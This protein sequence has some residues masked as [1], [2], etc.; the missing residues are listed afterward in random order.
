MSFGP[1][2][3]T[4]LSKDVPHTPRSQRQSAGLTRGASVLPCPRRCPLGGHAQPWPGGRAGLRGP[5]QLA[6]GEQT[7]ESRP[8]PQASPTSPAG[9]G[10]RHCRPTAAHRRRGTR[11]LRAPPSPPLAG[12]PTRSRFSLRGGREG[13]LARMPGS[14]ALWGIRHRFFGPNEA[15][16][17]YKHRARMRHTEGQGRAGVCGE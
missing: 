1:P 7:P 2:P 11:S 14:L 15:E 16:A 5:Q 10:A 12:V 3:G 8:P 4:V 6:R 9:S 13:W 17:E